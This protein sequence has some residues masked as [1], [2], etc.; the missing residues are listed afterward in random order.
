MK[1]FRSQKQYDSFSKILCDQL[2]VKYIPSKYIE[3]QIEPGK[4]RGG[5]FDMTGIPQSEEHKK[6]R[7]EALKGNA[8]CGWMKGKKWPKETIQKMK[9]SAK[10]RNESVEYINKQSD[11]KNHLKTNYLITDPKGNTFEVFGINQFCKQNGL[12]HSAMVLVAQGKRK[13]HKGW[14]CEYKSVVS[15]QQM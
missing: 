13:H 15:V 5:Y 3:P 8:N 1:L 14:K 12:T 11:A 2:N 7:S 6:A 9:I 10:K 4:C